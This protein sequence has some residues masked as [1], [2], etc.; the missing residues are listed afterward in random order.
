[1]ATTDLRALDASV[2]PV[3][4]LVSV[5]G[6]G[7][8]VDRVQLP[9]WCRSVAV[10]TL[11]VD[12]RIGRTRNQAALPNL[13]SS[14]VP[15]WT[16]SAGASAVFEVSRASPELAVYAASATTLELELHDGPEGLPRSALRAR[17]RAERRPAPG[18]GEED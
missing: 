11:T 13:A 12:A 10:Q 6:D 18:C 9:A 8:T 14:S 17:Y 1:M 5:T 16:V 15:R 3:L 2:E 7:S 4:A